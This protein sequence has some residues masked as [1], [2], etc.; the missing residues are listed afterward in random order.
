MEQLCCV[1]LANRVLC[2]CRCQG[3]N[4][5]GVGLSF[6]RRVMVQSQTVDVKRLQPWRFG[7]KFRRF[8]AAGEMMTSFAVDLCGTIKCI[9]TVC[10]CPLA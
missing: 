3:D 6:R 7:L 8:L 10:S 1:G 5:G 9:V 2:S 4:H